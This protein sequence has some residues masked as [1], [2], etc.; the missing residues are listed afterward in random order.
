MSLKEQWQAWADKIAALSQRE[1]VLILLTGVVWRRCH[2][3]LAGWG[4]RTAGAGAAGA[5][6]CPAGSGDRGSRE[7]GQAGQTGARSGSERAYPAGTAGWRAGQ[8]GR[9]TQGPDGGS[10]PGPRD[11]CRAGGP[12][13]A[14]RQSAHGGTHVADAGA[15]DGGRAAHQPVQARHPACWRAA[16]SMCISISRRWRGCRATSTGSSLTTRC[17]SIPR[18]WWRWRSTPL[19]TSKEFIR[20]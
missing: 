3:W 12:A 1:R 13:V 6:H 15:A 16:I 20:G 2:L 9:R 10:D 14:L 19:S 17:R 8:A 11:A 5:E 7:P 18:R 4:R